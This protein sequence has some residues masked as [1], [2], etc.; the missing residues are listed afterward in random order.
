MK[1]L[2]KLSALALLFTAIAFGACTED[3]NMGEIIDNTE[4]NSPSPA[5]GNGNSSTES[6]EDKPGG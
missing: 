2:K 3:A 4:I 6:E 5:S 1:N